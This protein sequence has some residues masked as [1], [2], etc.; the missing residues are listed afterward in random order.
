VAPVLPGALVKS[1][2]SGRGFISPSLKPLPEFFRLGTLAKTP[3]NLKPYR[4][5]GGHLQHRSAVMWNFR[6]LWLGELLRI[7]LP[8]TPVN[9]DES[10][11]K[12]S[13]HPKE[14]VELS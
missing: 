2:D 11:I 4:M 1:E 7:P 3:S 9:K 5:L 6:E 8:R 14:T 10:G 13:R 12:E